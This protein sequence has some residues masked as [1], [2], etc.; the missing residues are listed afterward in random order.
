MTRIYSST[1]I[2]RPIERVFDY[3]TTPGNWPHWHPS[4]LGVSGAV[5]HSLDLGERVTEDFLV[6][7]RRGR[8]VW[9]VYERDYPRHWAISGVIAGRQ[10]GGTVR[11]TLT[12]QAGG[13]FFEREFTYVAPSALFAL[14]DWLVL[15]KRIDA[16]SRWA[17]QR[18][19]WVLDSDP[20]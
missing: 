16:E 10:N 7:G 1:H 12:A 9:T 17:L 13:A 11:Y 4:S 19:K 20:G 5:D 8:V 14:M 2:R 18:L 15:R 3:V 6:A